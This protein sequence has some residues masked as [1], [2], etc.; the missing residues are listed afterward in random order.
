MAYS[1]AQELAANELEKAGTTVG[2]SIVKTSE[3]M[4]RRLGAIAGIRGGDQF[5]EA[6]SAALEAILARNSS[7]VTR[8]KSDPSRN[9]DDNL[10][11]ARLQSENIN[12][13]NELDFRRKFTASVERGGE[14]AAY[15]DFQNIDPLHIE[16]LLDQFTRDRTDAARSADNLERLERGF[17]RVG[18]FGG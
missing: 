4:A 16:R 6:G 17:R 12:V 1:A 18:F 5:N 7:S 14:A 15:R 10:E 9:L 11:I 3:V 2:A 13:R 8:L